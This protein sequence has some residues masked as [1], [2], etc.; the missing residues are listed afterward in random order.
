MQQSTISVRVGIIY[1][2]PR[3]TID[4]IKSQELMS[5]LSQLKRQGMHHFIQIWKMLRMFYIIK[6]YN[7]QLAS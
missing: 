4:S 2:A 1:P 7:V 6:L 5:N 3:L